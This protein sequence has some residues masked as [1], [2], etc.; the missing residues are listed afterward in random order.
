MCASIR[1]CH[2][3]TIEQSLSRV[4]SIPW[5]FVRTFLP[6]TSS[7]INLN[8][9]KVISSFCRSASE[10]SKTRPFR[11]SAAIPVARNRQ[12]HYRVNSK[13][14][15]TLDT[16]LF[17]F[18]SIKNLVSFLISP[19]KHN[20]MATHSRCLCEASEAPCRGWGTSYEYP[21]HVF[22]EKYEKI[23]ILFSVRAMK[24]LF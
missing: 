9:L 20:I 7:A 2:F 1:V 19:W 10:T 17:F 14:N 12:K 15:R 18:F 4:R 5:K 22:V 21:Q 8:F 3:F 16:E 24:S 23:W 11:P 6:W 13:L